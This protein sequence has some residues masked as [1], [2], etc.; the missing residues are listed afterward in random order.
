[1]IGKYD[2]ISLTLTETAG[3]VIL[4]KVFKLFKRWGLSNS[5]EFFK[6][7]IIHFINKH[8]GNYVEDL[9]KN[10]DLESV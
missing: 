4:S 2:E 5:D 6:K 1:M 3:F 10:Q 8:F 9:G 7:S